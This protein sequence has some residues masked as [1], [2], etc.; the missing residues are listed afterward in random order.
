MQGATPCC[1]ETFPVF[2]LA[3]NSVEPSRRRIVIKLSS[4]RIIQSRRGNRASFVFLRV[5]GLGDVM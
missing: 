5:S 4:G 3:I 1:S 2:I